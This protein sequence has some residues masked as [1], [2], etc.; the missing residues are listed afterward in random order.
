MLAVPK[1]IGA[2]DRK[3]I[4]LVHPKDSG[5]DFFNHKSFF[6]IVLLTL[7]DYDYKFIY[8]D[9]RYQWRISN[10]G[11]YRNSS[12]GKA[13]SNDTLNFPRPRPLLTLHENHLS[14]DSEIIEIPFVFIADDALP[15]TVNIMKPYALRI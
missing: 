12:L 3:H 7:V 10:G 1:C 8:V 6:S 2:C 4:V 14:S 5:F 11:F 13:L 9:V 15:L